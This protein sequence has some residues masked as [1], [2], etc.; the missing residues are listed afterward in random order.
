MIVDSER[1]TEGTADPRNLPADTAAVAA[2]P[3]AKVPAAEISDA[4]PR[5]IGTI[6]VV[7]V[8]GVFGLWSV[9]AP[10]DSAA[11]AQG[12]VAVKGHRKTV[13]HFEGGIVRE[14]LVRDGERVEAGQALLELDATQTR[15]EL[16]IVMGQ[17]YAVRALADRLAAER[18]DA[19]KI[20][21]SQELA[22]KDERAREA[23]LNEESIFAARREERLGK[24]R[25][26]ELRIEQLEAQVDGLEALVAA[27]RSVEALLDEE[28]A[29]LTAL[30]DEGYVDKQRLRE[31]QR[32]RS[33]LLGDIA[34]HE[35]SLAA[36]RVRIG[37]TQQEI[38]Q[39]QR[40]FV[41]EVA[42]Q[43]AEA[44]AN[45][46]EVM[47]RRLTLE[48]RNQ[49]VVLR[50][51]VSGIAFGMNTHTIGAVV[52]PGDTLL[53]I[54]PEDDELIIDAK[55]SPADIDRVEAGTQA[56]I[57]F[58]AFKNTYTVNGTLTK[59]SADRLIDEQNGMPYYSAQVAIDRDE[60]AQR[61]G[62]GE[63]LPGMPAEVLIKT[64]ERTLF[65]YLVTPASN[66]LAR[67]MIED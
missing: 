9:L 37:E 2:A 61:F 65:Q 14:I 40:S 57:R 38:L 5:R 36:V 6:I 21:F 27:K 13:Q 54:V 51:P 48:D 39:L 66:M 67:S 42:D 33:S 10:L 44:Q 3:A 47:Q 53:E 45:L 30:L 4:K 56:E 59:V 63:L 49:R 52:K 55:L 18:A 29:D 43:I 7:L 12:V 17:F 22:V 62:E 26:L 31:L 8:F 35:S 58:S 15:A 46:F 20:A 60:L 16:G 41:T 23:I 11:L 1:V 24:E 28:I 34:D 32:S 64:G 19:E 25:V 50:A